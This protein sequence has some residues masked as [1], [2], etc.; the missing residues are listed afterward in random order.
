MFSTVWPKIKITGMFPS[1]Q[2][3]EQKQRFPVHFSMIFAGWLP[4]KSATRQIPVQ[5]HTE[6]FV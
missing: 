5:G 2:A 6:T 4:A 3:N 1:I